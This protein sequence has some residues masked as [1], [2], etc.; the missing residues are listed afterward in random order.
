MSPITV[1]LSLSIGL[2]FP[3]LIAQLSNYL[4]EHYGLKNFYYL[5]HYYLILITPTIWFYFYFK[6]IFIIVMY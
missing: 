3:S 1:R 5:R 2:N 6:T 4:D